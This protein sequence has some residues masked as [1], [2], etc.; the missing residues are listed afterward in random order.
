MRD[1]QSDKKICFSAKDGRSRPLC[2]NEYWGI[3]YKRSIGYKK[4]KTTKAEEVKKKN[5]R[6]QMK[7]LER[8][9]KTGREGRRTPANET[10][11]IRISYAW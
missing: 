10:K 8:K 4:K 3:K 6:S 5:H 7:K 9:E 1:F 11:K 2:D